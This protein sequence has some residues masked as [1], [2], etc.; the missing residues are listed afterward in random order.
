ML[1]DRTM[2]KSPD[3]IGE[4]K[5]KPK[6]NNSGLWF[7]GIVLFCFLP[8]FAQTEPA[9]RSAD[10]YKQDVVIYAD[11]DYYASFPEIVSTVD[12]LVVY[13][14][15]QKISE[16]KASG[17][18]PHYQPVAH[19]Y[20]AV[21]RDPGQSWQYSDDPPVLKNVLATTRC[22]LA[23][24]EDQ[25]LD[26]RYRYIHGTK[27]FQH[28]GPAIFSGSL[29][30]N[31]I[32]EGSFD[33]LGPCSKPVVWDIKRL[34]DGTLLAAAY[35]DCGGA[36]PDHPAEGDDFKKLWPAELRMTTLVFYQGSPDGHHWR[37]LSHI[38]NQ[39]AFGFSEPSI[40]VFPDG[41]ILA[42]MRTD[43]CNEF[44]SLF[45]PDA[46][47]SADKLGYYLYQ[48]ESL[49]NG[50]TWSP[51]AQTPVWGHPPY[52]VPL[53]SGKLLMVLGHRTPP[54]GTQA[55]VSTDQG[56]TWNLKT[57]K[58][59]NTWDP[60]HYDLGYPVAVQLPDGRI[61]SCCY[62]YSASIR[63]DSHG[64]FGCLFNE[65]WLTQEQPLETKK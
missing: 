9:G 51:P 48:S 12:S 10:P 30:K 3:S 35:G 25:L 2:R 42:V 36:I 19:M 7:T 15:R 45:P 38:T 4:N 11:G 55:V 63:D 20:Y 31:K 52:L 47:T 58:M 46:G 29:Y 49:D 28:L 54:F 22:C 53:Q 33:E 26:M 59:L 23:L 24:P 16:L 57:L 8:V 40:A 34:K 56:R 65:Q 39:H 64:I 62:G 13:F 1:D 61:F 44:K 43:W 60:G 6:G 50:K 17:L 32:F 5:M 37:Y 14:E 27:E 41:R 21:S 18:H